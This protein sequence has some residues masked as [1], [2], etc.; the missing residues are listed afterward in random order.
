MKH[1][2]ELFG[3]KS[4][5]GFADLA[6]YDSDGNGWIDEADAGKRSMLLFPVIILI[7]DRIYLI[8]RLLAVHSKTARHPRQIF[9]P[10]VLPAK[11]ETG[12]L[13]GFFGSLDSTGENTGQTEENGKN[14]ANLEDITT[15]FHS[16]TY[17]LLPRPPSMPVCATDCIIRD[18]WQ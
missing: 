8:D 12:N 3:T 13:G 4:G 2:R 9:F 15:H 1:P 17:L 6:K 11:P 18:A 7:C 5:N 14:N 16:H 10:H